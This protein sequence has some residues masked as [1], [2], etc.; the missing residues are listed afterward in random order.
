LTETFP[1]IEQEAILSSGSSLLVSAGPGTGKTRTA[2]AKSEIIAASLSKES[3]QQVILLSFSNASVNRLRE[4]ASHRLRAASVQRLRFLT[5]H[6][7]AAELLRSYGRFVGL[8]A[9]I[10]V[11]DKLEQ[12]LLVLERSIPAE[13]GTGHEHLM[14]LAKAEGLIA[15]ECLIPLATSLLDSVPVIRRVLERRYPLIVVDEFQDTSE[16]QWH[17]L[18]ALGGSSQVIAFGDPNQIIYSSLHG[19]TLERMEQF[20]QWKQIPSESRLGRN[21]RCDRQAILDFAQC[22]LSGSRYAALPSPILKFI[23]IWRDSELR[24]KVAIE[25]M[26]RL[27]SAPDG[28]TV[29]ILVPSNSVAAE[30]CFNLRN[31]SAGAVPG[32]S[33]FAKVPRDQA[34]NDAILLLVFAMK[35]YAIM[36][37]NEGLR[38]VAMASL[39]MQSVFSSS[40]TP[41]L[42]RLENIVGKLERELHKPESKLTRV[43]AQL[44]AGQD[45]IDMVS[46]CVD[47]LA[48]I[49]TLTTACK[50]I[51]QEQPA[52]FHR[53][54]TASN[55]LSLFESFRETRQPKGLEG[56]SALLGRTHAMNFHKTKGCEFSHV[57]MV[58]DPRRVGGAPPIEEQ[59]RLM[60]VC[61]TRA[62]KTL[63]I[64]YYRNRSGAILG[65]ALPLR[66]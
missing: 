58:V 15:F 60:Y 8:P 25:W 56:D 57:I 19:A 40:R 10:R 47:S 53:P 49:P 36:P 17:F 14:A 54:V 33:V 18:R 64:I 1:S 66:I 32:F 39:A 59:R 23:S 42:E 48:G 55:Q 16:A 6:S 22:L 4:E 5:Y 62:K 46:F 28:E 45:V 21:F 30:L 20:M 50:R 63:S 9:T 41:P 26:A 34:G 38:K 3:L 52:R 12:Q 43:V 31:P 29:G 61:A 27:H 44:A 37:S 51:A 35:D 24:S 7:L 13:G 65:P 2:I 11:M